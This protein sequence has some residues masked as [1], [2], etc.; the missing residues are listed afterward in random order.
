MGA[1]QVIRRAGV[2]FALTLLAPATAQARDYCSTRPSLGQS[3]CILDPGRVAIETALTDWERDDDSDTTL[4]GDSLLRIGVTDSAELQLGWTP[5]GI[6]RD[7]GD[8]RRTAR[9]GDATIGA[10][11]NLRN[12]DGKGLSY[13]LQPSIT[14]P[15]GRAPIGGPG[16]SAGVVAPVTYDLS[17]AINLQF[18]PELDLVADEAGAGHHLEPSAVVGVDA[19]LS[20][21]VETTAELQWVHEQSGDAANAALSFAWKLDDDLL[22]DAGAMVGLNDQAAAFRL[23]SGISRRF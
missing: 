7:R 10:R 15:V 11:I 4:F 14:L 3:A 22:V 20:E 9:T 1:A 18:S 8:G 23:Y 21:T 6:A 17:D 16:W 5:L 12:P 13:G 19:Q 2:L